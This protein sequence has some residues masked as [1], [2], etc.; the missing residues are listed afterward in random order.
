MEKT[1]ILGKIECRRKRGQQRTR[2][3]NDITDSID[4]SVSKPWEITKDREAWLPFMG[5]Q[6][7]EHDLVME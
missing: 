5:L 1:L 7:I 3:L 4:M 2:W 6:R